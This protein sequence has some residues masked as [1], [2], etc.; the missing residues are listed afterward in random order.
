MHLWYVGN[1][2]REVVR[3]VTEKKDREPARDESR[4]I[5]AQV[6]QIY[7]QSRTGLFGAQASA[8]LLPLALWN[9]VPWERLVIWVA[10]YFGIQIPRNLLV[11]NVTKDEPSDED[12]P[13]LG[14]WFSLLTIAAG[15]AWGLAGILLFPEGSRTHQFILAL[16]LTGI[17]SASAVVYSPLTSCYAPTIIAVLAPLTVYYFFMGSRVDTLIGV[18]ILIFTGV[19]V[20]TGRLMH[21]VTVETLRLRFVNQDLVGSLVGEKETVEYLNTDLMK[22]IEGRRIV[23]EALRVEKSRFQ[24]LVENLPVGTVMIGEDGAYQYVNPKFIE[25]FGYA[26]SAIPHG[27]DW[28]RKAFPDSEYRHHVIRN[29]FEDLD[30]TRTGELRPRIYHVRCHD[31][32]TKVVQF[33]PVQLDTGQ[34][35]VACQDITARIEAEEALRRSEKQF[36]TLVETVQDVIWTVGMNLKLTYVS[37]FVT[38]LLGYSVD[39]M[40]KL[41]P[42]DVLEPESRKKVLGTL[43]EALSHDPAGTLGEQAM[44]VGEVE[45]YRKDGTKV[46]GEITGSFIR[47][48]NG[49]PAGILGVVHDISHRKNAEE[50]L[51]RSEHTAR[52]LLNATTDEAVLVGNDGTIVACNETFAR[53]FGRTVEEVTGAHIEKL[54]PRDLRSARQDKVLEVIR[55]GKSTQFSDQHQGNHFHHSIHPVFDSEGNVERLAI[56]SEDTTDQWRTLHE[57]IAAKEMAEGASRAKTEFLTTMSHELRTPLNAII[58][59]SEMLEDEL[60]GT[61]NQAQRR[62]VGH[63]LSSGRHLL[64]LI[65]SI[66]DLAKVESGKMELQRSEVNLKTVVNDSL[67]MIR[68]K[69]QKHDLTIDAEMDEEVNAEPIYADETK[70]R[71]IM[72]N[73]LSNAVKF[74]PERGQVRT[75]VVMEDG[76]L[77][78]SVSDSGIGLR[79]ED[80]ERIF[81][82]FE[83]LDSSLKRRHDGT[84]LGLALTRRFVELHGG[85]I[86]AE[87]DGLN[88][89][90]TFTFT[91]PVAKQN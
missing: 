46:W 28:F 40:M 21:K 45:L 13:R 74:T 59:F 86:W 6:R 33:W 30:A 64:H 19:L 78:V 52:S 31:G 65:N 82:A 77:V 32:T 48:S 24:G 61:L 90:S 4:L 51:I 81:G 27:R 73:L 1:E 17:S 72:Y 68:D 55:T 20:G 11:W 38:K 18:A 76:D 57:L 2:T 84:G 80:I 42:L 43:D 70:L 91:I 34:R 85:R 67:L 37:P 53:R 54:M 75:R 22:E 16:F 71:Q 69:S 29:W 3:I 44:R 26:P 10:L 79:A 50:A 9:V 39:E 5:A 8:L 87:S 89:G 62:Y 60:F 23:E 66:L 88:R 12:M 56:F 36:R 83:Q 58:G 49:E 41:D 7:A 35:L 14:R 15:M 47:D 63:V 25:L